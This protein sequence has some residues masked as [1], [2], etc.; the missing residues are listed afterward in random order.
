MAY[1]ICLIMGVDSMRMNSSLS[2][3]LSESRQLILITTS[4]WDAVD[5]EMRLYER[6]SDNDQW[7]AVGEKIPVV[8]GRNGMAWG[9]GLHAGAGGCG[10][11][12]KEGD[13]R[14][15]AGVFS[16]SSAFG[17]APPEQAGELKL[18]YAQAVATLECV[19]DPQ[20][21]H[22][23]RIVD[24]ARVENPDWKSSERMRRDDDQYRWGVVVDHNAKGA[25]VCGSCIFIHIWEFPGKGTAGCSAMSSLSIEYLLRWLDAEKR[26]IL[27]QLPQPEFERLRESWGLTMRDLRT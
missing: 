13:G 4:G 19:D 18:P 5:G 1:H 11:V 24:R 10:L 23:N 25:P 26:P 14:S 15:P 8:I 27:V 20:S 2:E 7:N 9:S 6:R 16:L 17:Y 21:A 3:S 22:Y 12:K